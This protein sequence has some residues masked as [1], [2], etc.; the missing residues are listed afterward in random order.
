MSEKPTQE[1]PNTAT[2][3]A[4]KPTAPVKKFAIAQLRQNCLALFKVSQSA[5]DGATYGLKGEYTVEEMR[6]RIKAW[7]EK[8]AP[9]GRP[10]KK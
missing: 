1:L 8:P 7:G 5:F 10:K 6:A 2:P 4:G 3:E 9:T